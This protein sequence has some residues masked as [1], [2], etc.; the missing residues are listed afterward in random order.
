MTQKYA[1][2]RG[3]KA[4]FLELRHIYAEGAQHTIAHS[5][6]VPDSSGGCHC[7]CLSCALWLA[8]PVQ[9]DSRQHAPKAEG[10]EREEC[11]HS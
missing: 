7:C 4:H 5:P 9:S 3:K 11:E 2:F 6:A 8:E 1:P 10:E